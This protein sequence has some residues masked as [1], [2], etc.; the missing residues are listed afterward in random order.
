MDPCLFESTKRSRTNNTRDT[1]VEC[2]VSSMDHFSVVDS[3]PPPLAGSKR[4]R[5]IITDLLMESSSS[6]STLAVAFNNTSPVL[7]LAGSKRSWTGITEYTDSHAHAVSNISVAVIGTFTSSASAKLY[8]KIA[9]EV[10]RIAK[11]MARLQYLTTKGSDALNALDSLDTLATRAKVDLD[12][13]RVS[14][15]KA[16]MELELR[17]VA[18]DALLGRLLEKTGYKL[19]DLYLATVHGADSSSSS[20]TSSPRPVSSFPSK[21]RQLAREARELL[22]LPL[23]EVDAALLA[24]ESLPCIS[25]LIVANDTEGLQAALNSAAFAGNF[26]DIDLLLAD[27]R[28]SPAACFHNFL[29]AAYKAGRTDMLLALLSENRMYMH[30]MKEGAVRITL[31]ETQAERQ[32]AFKLFMKTMLFAY[33][34]TDASVDALVALLATGCINP[35]ASSSVAL[36]NAVHARM[37]RIVRALL[38]DPRVDP[39]VGSISALAVGCEDSSAK[40][41]DMLRAM[42]ADKRS[43]PAVVSALAHAVYYGNLRATRMLLA[44]PRVDCQGVSHNNLDDGQTLIGI[45]VLYGNS[46]ALDMLLKDG[47][48]DPL[49]KGRCGRPLD[50]AAAGGCLD[51][52][53]VLMADTRVDPSA[54]NNAA[55][56]AAYAKAHA[57]VANLLLTDE[58]VKQV[59]LHSP[60]TKN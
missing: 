38:T 34:E 12:A 31:M 22:G 40:G 27:G 52:V 57:D 48:A 10:R 5:S 45:A 18:L 11:I 47:R 29:V 41:A 13:V 2:I 7:S 24:Y 50:V 36:R 16:V 25:H 19:Q 6:S 51:K 8:Y 37:P 4:T 55:L 9:A 20:S 15:P 14:G 53:R 44:D 3:P 21:M 43:G 26:L 33:A 54:H 59:E 35:G 46:E 39:S 56:R 28:V 30:S 17:T 58:R 49:A 32:V 60:A 23:A 42:L 1:D